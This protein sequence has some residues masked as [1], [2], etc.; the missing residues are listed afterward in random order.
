MTK[1]TNRTL[2]FA[3]GACK[4]NPGRGGFSATNDAGAIFIDPQPDA[5]LIEHTFDACRAACKAGSA[6]LLQPSAAPCQSSDQQD[7]KA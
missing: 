5:A 4:D 3:D 2:L 1:Q 6:L 7:A